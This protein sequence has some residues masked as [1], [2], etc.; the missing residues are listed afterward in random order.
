VAD[1]TSPAMTDADVERLRERALEA[2]REIVRA[3]RRAQAGHLGGP[4]S[5][6]DALV[7]LY[8]GILR[9]RPDEP[10]WFERDRFVLSKGHASIGLYSVLALSGYFPVEEL[11]T[12][13]AVGTRLQGHPDMTRLP[14]LDMST[15]S[16]GVG[17]SAAVGM[18]IGARRRDL[19]SR[20][21]VM[22]GDGECQEGQVWEAAISAVRHRLDNLFAIVDVN[23]LQQFGW[24]DAD[25]GRRTRPWSS[26]ALAGIWAAF[27][28]RTATIDGHDM[29]AILD[30]I[31]A[32]IAGAGD[33]RPTVI[34]AETVKGRGVSFMEDRFEW[35]ARVPS[36]D[37]AERALRELGA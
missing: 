18:A 21:F 29:R 4:L 23:G 12:F 20:V 10:D 22:L 33:G 30:G 9:V 28:W 8:G 31:G 17:I 14:G 37:E 16:L 24:T 35:H 5:A 11:A 25:S 2:R 3:V 26:A 13:D 32:A 34:L 36:D 7:A 6:V 27:G 19:D 1:V 15:G